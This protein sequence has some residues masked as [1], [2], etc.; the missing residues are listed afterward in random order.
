VRG[1]RDEAAGDAL[2]LYALYR[3]EAAEEHSITTAEVGL[4]S[5][6]SDIVVPPPKTALDLRRAITK[7]LFLIED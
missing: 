1:G 7:Q 4:G 5:G 2:G 3:T 6:P